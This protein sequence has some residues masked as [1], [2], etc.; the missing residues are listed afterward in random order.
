MDKEDIVCNGIL[1]S[2]RNNEIMSFAAIWM[3]LDM[4]TLSEVKEK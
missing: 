3:E 4:I 2:Q 1:L